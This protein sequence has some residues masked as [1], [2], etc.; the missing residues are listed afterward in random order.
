MKLNFYLLIS[1]ILLLVFGT[2]LQSAAAQDLSLAKW[3]PT[4]SLLTARV[5]HTATLL[6][7]GKV[8]IV[9][10]WGGSEELASVELYDPNEGVFAS[11]S[12]LGSCRTD[13]TATLLRNGQ[14]LVV[15]GQFHGTTLAS[16]ELY[17]PATGNWT[18]TGSLHIARA[19]HTATLLSD[20]EVLVAGGSRLASPPVYPQGTPPGSALDIAELYDPASGKWTVVDNLHTARYVHTATLLGN[21]QVLVTGGIGTNG[22][23]NLE[24]SAELYNPTAKSWTV[25]QSL[26]SPLIG[27]TAT[28]L[29]N[30]QV[31]VVGGK[32][33]VESDSASAELY[34]PASGKWTSTGSLHETRNAHSATL[35]SNGQ[36]LVV[37]GNN[38]TGALNSAEL[39]DPSKGTWET[40]ASTDKPHGLQTATLLPNGQVL[41]TGGGYAVGSPAFVQASAELYTPAAEP[42]LGAKLQSALDKIACSHSLPSDPK[43]SSL[44]TFATCLVL[45]T[46]CIVILTACVVILLSAWLVFV[47]IRRLRK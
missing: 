18:S 36:V 23:G 40:T 20:G 12:G 6:P 4:G 3:T 47:L 11:A 28:L 24:A 16:A 15:G 13:H 38:S 30:G 25:T 19:Y 2:G 31:L 45:I 46:S 22:P 8:L 7:N 10:G 1:A 43:A 32:P 27:H 17:N 26:L 9:A 34:N 39:Y 35:L 5:K 44:L 33:T 29:P 42:S 14:V 37:G 21:G 41:V